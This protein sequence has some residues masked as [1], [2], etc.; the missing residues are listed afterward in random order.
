MC[1][2]YGVAVFMFLSG[3]AIKGRWPSGW[4]QT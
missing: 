4:V 2:V 3:P 1:T